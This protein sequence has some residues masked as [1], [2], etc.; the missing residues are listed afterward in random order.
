MSTSRQ[1]ALYVL[2]IIA[3][4]V[5][6]WVGMA[7]A[8]SRPS[9]E[10]DGRCSA[11]VKELEAEVTS[12]RKQ[13]HDL[14]NGNSPI[15]LGSSR[16]PSKLAAIANPSNKN[17]S[18][19]SC[20]PPFGYDQHGIKYYRPG[21]LDSADSDCSVPYAYT[22]TG[23][24]TYKPSCLD[25]TAAAPTSCDSPFSFDAQGIKSYKPECL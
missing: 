16:K 19:A 24:K 4:A 5:V 25:G 18:S 14:S 2:G 21:C 6:G 10:V 7:T 9:Q 17:D 8:K 22:S 12:L 23:I 20:D 1:P 13:L 15:A 3:V 11:R